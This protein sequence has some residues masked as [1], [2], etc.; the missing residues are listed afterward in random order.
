M[1]CKWRLAVDVHS[2]FAKRNVNDDHETMTAERRQLKFASLDEA[3]RDAE[4]LLASGYEQAGN[5]DLTQCCH[6]LAVL[7][8]Y[9]I[10]GFPKFSFPLNVGSWLLKQTV[11]HRYLNRVLESGVWPAGSPTD[12]R[13]V[14]STGGN[15]EEAV[16]RLKQAAE[17]LQ[18]HTGSFQPSPLFGMLDKETLLKLHRI[19]TAHHLSF[20]VPADANAA[21]K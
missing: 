12:K 5:W 18:S 8:D 3:V 17:R 4:Q 21:S 7:M 20:L 15:D 14:P 13:T 6:H 16:A 19:H 1:D 2:N 10:D 11:A 9:P